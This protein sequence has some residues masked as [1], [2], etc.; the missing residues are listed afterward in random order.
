MSGHQ[1]HLQGYTANQIKIGWDIGI[2]NM[3]YCQLRPANQ[4]NLLP[5]PTTNNIITV[6]ANS[7]QIT[8]W[9]IINVVPKVNQFIHDQGEITLDT[10]PIIK[11]CATKT[12]SKKLA[13]NTVSTTGGEICGKP[14]AH[15]LISDPTIGY[16]NTHYK[17]SLHQSIADPTAT[18]EILPTSCRC[19]YHEQSPSGTSRCQT[20]AV[21]LS[22]RNP[23]IG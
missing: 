13:G 17:T 21:I 3:S 9:E 1:Q 10:R 8:G 18:V 7:Y 12:K 23:Y 20:G 4:T 16:C 11:C 22:A 14:A 15:C 6:G 19:W 2:K 5:N